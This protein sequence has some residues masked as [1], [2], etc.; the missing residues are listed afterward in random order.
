VAK[1]T[2]KEVAAACGVSRATV[3]LVLQDSHRV[4]EGTKERVRVAMREMGYVYDRRAANLRSKRSM[5]VALVATDVRNPYFAELTMAIEAA[6][7]EQGYALL[8]GYSRDDVEHQ[9][10][11]LEAMIEHRVDGLLLV[12]SYETTGE[13][14]QRTLG[15]SGTPHV[16]VTR[17][18]QRYDA[19]YVGVDNVRAAELIGEHLLAEGYRRIA[20]LGGPAQSTARIERRRGLI[21][22]LERWEVAYDPAMSIATTADREGGVGAVEALFAADLRPD[23]V[24]CYSDVVAF[25]AMAALRGA[26]L[27][28]GVDIA[29]AS[30][31]DLPAAAQQQPTLT[32]V[33]SYPNRTGAEAAD[34]LRRR[35]D[36]PDLPPR[37]VLLA[38]ELHVRQSTVDPVARHEGGRL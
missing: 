33:A 29:V 37:T 36:D 35:M 20:F 13:M 6:L 14:L 5:T 26:G 23:A 7:Y 18:V 8:L 28:P 3:S 16:L 38:P 32:S 10:R 19:D 4:S 27:K 12:P 17:H 9:E 25:G 11:L 34:L 21:E 15:A 30:F 31:D 22:A 1:V 2:L 24:V